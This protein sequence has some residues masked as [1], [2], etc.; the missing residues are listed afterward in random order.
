[1][2]QLVAIDLDG[3]LLNS[4]NQVSSANRQAIQQLTKQGVILAIATGRSQYSVKKI[5]QELGV[6]GY[7]IGQ[8]G[9]QISRIEAGESELLYTQ[10]LGNPAVFDSFQLALQT[11]VT[12][13]ANTLQMSYKLTQDTAQLVQEFQMTRPDLV[14]LSVEQMQDVLFKEKLTFLKMAFISR[15]TSMLELLKNQFSEKGLNAFFSDRNY[16]ELIAEG[17]N[18]GAS[19]Q[20]LSHHLHIGRK[21]ILAFG[22]QE[23]DIE[24]LQYSGLG[25]AMGNAQ[26][27]IKEAAD[28]VTSSN[29]DS[30]VAKVLTKYFDL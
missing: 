20:W 10:P 27:K 19:L 17:V 6:D 24:M 29:N 7:L 18:K 16:I 25:I 15:D 12:V 23:N 13:I 9:A 21:E 11:K 4:A 8:N 30:G 22:D 14:E 28:S 3:T 26:R 1:M 2:K 5:F